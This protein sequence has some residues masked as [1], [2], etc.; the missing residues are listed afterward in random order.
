MILVYHRFDKEKR[1]YHT[2]MSAAQAERYESASP[3]PDLD[4][5]R[6]V[7]SSPA[8]CR[9]LQPACCFRLAQH[10]LPMTMDL[11]LDGWRRFGT[12]APTQWNSPPAMRIL[13]I[14]WMC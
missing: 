5:P 13:R 1:Q 14:A 11:P 6:E 2:N 8:I 12:S 9:S 4:L 7:F 10:L 3:C